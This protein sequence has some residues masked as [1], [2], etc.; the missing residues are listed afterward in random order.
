MSISIE[1]IGAIGAIDKTAVEFNPQV[2]AP[3]QQG[4][5]AFVQMLQD[6]VSEVNQTLSSAN[7]Q[8]E[9]LALDKPVSTHEL[10]ITMEKAKLQLS[11]AIEV[12]NKLV[13][14]YQEL[15][16]MQL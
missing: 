2:N 15:M 7:V 12:R 13:E 10:M 1:H 5:A 14:G 11:M 6:G 3:N 16:R 8:L 9:R 4:G